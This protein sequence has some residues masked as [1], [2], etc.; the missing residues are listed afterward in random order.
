MWQ[1][2]DPTISARSP[3][4]MAPSPIIPAWASIPPWAT[5]VAGVSPVASATAASERVRPPR[6]PAGPGAATS[7][8]ARRDRRPSGRRAA[9]RRGVPRS[10]IW[11]SR[12]R[13]SP[14]TA[15]QPVGQ[16]VGRLD[17]PRRP[18]I[19]LGLVPLEPQGLGEHPLGRQLA[20]AV[21]EVRRAESRERR[22]GLV[23][24]LVHPQERAQAAGPRRRAPRRCR[25]R[26]RRR[27]R[28]PRPA[29]RR[30]AR[31]SPGARPPSPATTSPD[32]ARPR[33]DAGGRSRRPAMRRRPA[34]R[35]GR[36]EPSGRLECPGRC[37][38][39]SPCGPQHS[40]RSRPALRRAR[41]RPRAT[42]SS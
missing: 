32:P 30:L 40:R 2:D 5:S 17:E 34:A 16:Q 35:P 8:A 1:V 42:H 6:R 37:R 24:A 41:S 23:G 31:R 14:S 19:R 38:R 21:A 13:G 39:G 9:T 3:A 20:A 10:P 4:S 12:C 26:S 36:R 28:G 27:G 33:R 22:G 7:R 15:R 29:G 11:R 25:R 18:R